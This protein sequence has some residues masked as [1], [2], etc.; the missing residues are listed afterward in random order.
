MRGWTSLWIG[1]GASCSSNVLGLLKHAEGGLVLHGSTIYDT[2]TPYHPN[3]CLEREIGTPR[4]RRVLQA[5]GGLL[6]A[7]SP[8]SITSVRLFNAKRR[9]R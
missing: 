9:F 8:L 2:L 5:V 7:I 3:T 1:E 6:K 4:A